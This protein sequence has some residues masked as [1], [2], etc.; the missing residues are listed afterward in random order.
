MRLSLWV[1]RST[2]SLL[3]AFNVRVNNQSTGC[4]AAGMK[5]LN[6]G[7]EKRKED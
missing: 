6:L 1:M 2:I 3:L 5:I 4:G 7:S